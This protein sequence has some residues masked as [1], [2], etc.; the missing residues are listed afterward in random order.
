MP[1][2]AA[3]AGFWGK[4]PARGDFVGAG[5]PAAAVAAF[6]DWSRAAIAE[7]RAALG[8]AWDARWMAAPIWR[9]RLGPAVAGPV[10]LAG[11]WLPSVDSVGRRFPL[12]LAADARH[13]DDAWLDAVE[14]L[15]LEAVTADLDPDS[16]AGRLPPA[17]AEAG[18]APLSRR[19][20]WWTAGGPYRR[21]GRFEAVM[22][23]A[24]ACFAAMLADGG[25]ADARR[26]DDRCAAPGVSA[27]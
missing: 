11:L 25:C 26:A 8:E 19:S 22:L 27:A 5:L 15:G 3:V 2:G 6:E 18:A 1:G 12:I 10:P 14:A 9:F 21:A 17:H 24:P 7:S 13:A 16:L 4:L 20:V 23:P